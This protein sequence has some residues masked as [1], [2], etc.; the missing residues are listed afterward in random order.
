MI[1]QYAVI[2]GIES[3]IREF[4]YKIAETC[5]SDVEKN[6]ETCKIYFE[7]RF[8]LPAFKQVSCQLDSHGNKPPTITSSYKKLSP[9]SRRYAK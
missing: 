7:Y 9:S 3:D 5:N 8:G 1:F 4:D 6:A 2:L